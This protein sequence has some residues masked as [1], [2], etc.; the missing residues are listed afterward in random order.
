MGLS[1]DFLKGLELDK[2]TIDAIMAE[3][4]SGVTELKEQIETIKSENER[5]KKSSN[6]YATLQESFK[7]L[8]QKVS[9]LT[10]KNQKLS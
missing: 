3:Y 10:N 6:E 2:S 9:D 4:G 1:R 5:L 7:G 8:Q